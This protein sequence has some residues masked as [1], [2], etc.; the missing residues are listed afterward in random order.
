MGDVFHI[1]TKAKI[2]KQFLSYIFNILISL[3]PNDSA[4]W[5][6]DNTKNQMSATF[7]RQS[8]AIF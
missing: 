7:I 1:N 6:V 4:W 5:L 3:A 8:Y 2:N